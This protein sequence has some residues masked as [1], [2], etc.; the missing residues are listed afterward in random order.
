ME[1]IKFI[2]LY[3]IGV[4]LIFYPQHNAL[5]QSSS[6][7]KGIIMEL[8]SSQPIQS[9]TIT[10]LRTE[11]ETISSA[12]GSY[13]LQG[14]IDD[15]FSFSVPGYLADTAFIYHE[16]VVRTYLLRDEATIVINEVVISRFTDS[17][18]DHE[19]IKARREGEF[20][21]AGQ[22]RGGFRFSPSRLFGKDSK[23]ARKNLE[24]LIEEKDNRLI[25]R[26]FN[27][28]LIASLTGMNPEEIALFRER[29]RP[30]PDFIKLATDQDIRIYIMDS[31]G[32]FKQDR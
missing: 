22:Q 3:F 21:D 23:R 17:R 26:K 6:K 16:G 9:V 30:T 32:K 11:A 20:F 5:A 14:A 15:K 4:C 29:Y 24:I 19:I 10:N 2:I 25:D 13:E 27:N 1:Q 31:Y 7:I 28:T 12:D 8:E 18:L